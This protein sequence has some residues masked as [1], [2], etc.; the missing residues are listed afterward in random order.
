MGD[1]RLGHEVFGSSSIVVHCEDVDTLLALSEK[2]EG[3]LTATLQM[4]PGDVGIA[5]RLLPILE[6]K[7]G[8]ILANG[9]PPRDGPRRP[10]SSDLGQPDD[11]G[12]LARDAPVLAACLLSG[13][14]RG[15]VAPGTP[16][17][18]PAEPSP[19]AGRG[20]PGSSTC[21][22]KTNLFGDI[23]SDQMAGLV[24]GLGMAPGANIGETTAIFE[25][26]HG[27]APDIAGEG[28]ANPLALLLAAC[29]MLDWSC[30]AR[31]S[32]KPVHRKG[33]SGR[34]RADAGLGWESFDA[35]VL[36]GD[37]QSGCRLRTRG[38]VPKDCFRGTNGIV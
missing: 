13:P 30:G 28:I 17:R 19:I 24:G 23:L 38:S 25:A 34:Q 37:H 6:R 32:D 18:E 8:R 36:T 35:R 27:S 15:S 5:R 29:L 2:L 33:F 1:E 12:R 10:V 11:I 3:Q 22:S 4:D 21:S 26:V 16:R 7:A 31:R 20:I 14:G 9:W